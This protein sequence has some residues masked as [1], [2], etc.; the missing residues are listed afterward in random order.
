ML[1]SRSTTAEGLRRVALGDRFQGSHRS[2]LPISG[3]GSS[4]HVFATGR[5]T[6]WIA[7]AA[8]SGKADTH[9]P[10]PHDGIT[11]PAGSPKDCGAGNAEEHRLPMP[12]R[13]RTGPCVAHVHSLARSAPACRCRSSEQPDK[14]R[15]R[16]QA[17]VPGAGRSLPLIAV[18][19]HPRPDCR[20]P[21]VITLE[22]AHAGAALNSD[23]PPRGINPL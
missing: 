2:G 20:D 1:G 18:R 11:A 4:S 23:R 14:I 13:A 22:V 10:P 3:T 8:G 12:A 9:A 5:H 16:K 15:E 7:I 21:R 6:E 19:C 17:D